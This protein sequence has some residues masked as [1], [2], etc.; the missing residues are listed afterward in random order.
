MCVCV[1]IYLHL[2]V[3]KKDETENDKKGFLGDHKG[4]KKKLEKKR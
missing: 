2:L 4:D 3:D 1:E